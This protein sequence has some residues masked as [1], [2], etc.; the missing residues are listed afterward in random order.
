[1]SEKKGKHFSY[2]LRLLKTASIDFSYKPG[3]IMEEKIIRSI[4]RQRFAKRIY[5]A[6]IIALFVVI[7]FFL[8]A[9]DLRFDIFKRFHLIRNTHSLAIDNQVGNFSLNLDKKTP[10]IESGL[11][12]SDKVS[13]DESDRMF[14]MIKYVVIANDGGW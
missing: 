6:A 3:P 2:Y 1:M 10:S 11:K 12:I 9:G 4:K 13:N 8:G 5:R 7:I 14:K